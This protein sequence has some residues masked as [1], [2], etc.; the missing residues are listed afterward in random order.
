MCGDYFLKGM[1]VTLEPFKTC[2][3]TDISSGVCE[4]S[5]EAWTLMPPCVRD[6]SKALLTKLR[7]PR[8]SESKGNIP[9]IFGTPFINYRL[10][11]LRFFFPLKSSIFL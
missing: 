10:W 11:F 8:P 1:F 9:A 2:G 6:N 7:K 4:I 5:P 3:H